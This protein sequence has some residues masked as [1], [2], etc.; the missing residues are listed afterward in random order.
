MKLSNLLLF[1]SLLTLSMTVLIA[2]AGNPAD[3]VWEQSIF[4]GLFSSVFCCVMGAA[5]DANGH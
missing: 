1:G 4:A 5:I 3:P 2:F